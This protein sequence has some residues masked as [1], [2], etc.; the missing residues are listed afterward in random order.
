METPRALAAAHYRRLARLRAKLTSAVDTLWTPE[1]LQLPRVVSLVLTG[2]RAAVKMTDGYMAAAAS[3]AL[4]SR[5]VPVGL[6]A[7]RLIGR[8]AR[9]GTPL[10]EAYA[11]VGVVAEAEGAESAR[12]YLGQ[13]VG[14]DVQLAQRAAGFAIMS[15]SSAVVGWR[16][17]TGG[18]QTCARCTAASTRVFRRQELQPI[19][20][21]C[22]C[23]VAAV[24]GRSDR[25]TVD[26]AALAAVYAGGV[27]ALSDRS[28]GPLDVDVSRLPAGVDAEAIVAARVRIE[29]DPELGAVLDADR[30]DHVA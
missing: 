14:V 12:T 23:S 26:R 9:N 8:A 1:G 11:R 25:N 4:G 13:Q 22:G 19:H 29:H 17:V 7:E 16:R 18:G 5:E 6:D 2:Q 3:A 30:H 20:R 10:E 27:L 15:S 21:G 24:Y 28:T